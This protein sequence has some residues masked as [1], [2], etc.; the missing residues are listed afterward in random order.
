MRFF[1]LTRELLPRWQREL[2]ALEQLA[3]Y[4]LGGDAFR[5]SHGED[6]FAF[7]ERMG[8]VHY[9]A[10][11]DA[12]RLAG[13]GCG[14]LRGGAPRRWYLADL[15]IHPEYRGRH[16][17]VTMF[18]RAFLQNY[19]RCPRGYGVAMDPPDGRVPPAVRLLEHFKWIPY[20]FIATTALDIYSAGAE[21]MRAVL[22]ALAARRGPA[23]FAS[24]LG[25]KDL[26]LESTRAP[27][28]LL[29]LRFGAPVDRCVFAEPQ[30]G[31]THMW[32]VPR[33][34]ALTGE[35]S[36]LGFK[37]SASATIVHHGMSGFDWSAIDTSEI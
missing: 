17:P 24:L 13:V 14:V 7:F 29:H 37:P 3:V 32:C 9:Y 35:L 27:L 25:I 26:V 1:K 33:A 30:P 2:E 18:R 23:H 5:L 16:L 11:E 31:H 8:A 28:P 36:A 20:K 12:G 15:K 10:M 19:L 6:Y 21:Q 34:G 22:P 4:P